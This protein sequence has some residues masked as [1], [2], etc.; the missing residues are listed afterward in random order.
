MLA[1]GVIW[2]RHH[3]VGV[4][5]LG[6]DYM[7]IVILLGR[8]PAPKTYSP[9]STHLGEHHEV[10]GAA[11]RRKFDHPSRDTVG[12]AAARG[13]FAADGI[14]QLDIGPLVYV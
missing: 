11:L 4:E 5:R 9:R 10:T 3:D 8:Q 14:D 2:H 13:P 12:G 7:D 1:G 6:V